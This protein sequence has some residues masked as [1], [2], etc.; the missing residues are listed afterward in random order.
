MEGVIWLPAAIAERVNGFR[1]ARAAA[2]EKNRNERLR[3]VFCARSKFT[4]QVKH[5][6]SP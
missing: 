4:F 3:Y 5:T 1:A 6:C 2:I